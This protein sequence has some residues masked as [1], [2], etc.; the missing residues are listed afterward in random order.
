MSYPT[1]NGTGD[2]SCGALAACYALDQLGVGIMYPLLSSEYTTKVVKQVW[3]HIKFP[4]SVTTASKGA[5]KDGYSDPTLIAHRLRELGAKNSACYLS[6]KVYLP[7][8]EDGM[9][10][11]LLKYTK[12]E[13]EI[14]KE[15]G[16]T[17]L[18][19]KPGLL[20]ICMFKYSGGYHYVLT[21]YDN[22]EGYQIMDSNNNT[23]AYVSTKKVDI[24]TTFTAKVNG[25]NTDYTY[26]GLCI[27]AM[28]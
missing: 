28:K 13:S 3:N 16:I 20:G 4:K 11:G 24:T 17:K 1:Q 10:R 23:P 18:H 26:S 19:K 5:L 15:E 9:L 2:Q 12:K 7:P 21:R 22:T 27:L 25:R 14:K 6:S 8:A